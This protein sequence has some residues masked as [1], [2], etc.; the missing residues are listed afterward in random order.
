MKGANNLFYKLIQ[1][2][3]NIK[4]IFFNLKS[5]SADGNPIYINYHLM[6]SALSFHH[7]PY[8]ASISISHNYNSRNLPQSM[9]FSLQ[10]AKENAT[11]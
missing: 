5:V 4:Y 2:K 8:P 6:I 10:L 7:F 11:Y 3:K 9:L 1:Q